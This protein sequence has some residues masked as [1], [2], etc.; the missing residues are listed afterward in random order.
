MIY[1]PESSTSNNDLHTQPIRLVQISDSHLFKETDKTL[2]GLNTEQSFLAVLKLILQEQSRVDLLITTGDIAQQP[3][4]E[5][6][7]RYLALTSKIHAP[8]FCVQGNHDLKQPFYES[9]TKNEL[10]CEVVMG[11]WC[12]ILLDST[13]D[14]EISGSFSQKTLNYIDEALT[15]QDDKHVLIALH[16]NPIAVGCIWL[17]QHML[18]DS[19]AFLATINRHSNVKL[20]MHGHVH[21]A[22]EHIEQGIHYISCPSTSL[23]FK[24]RCK[25]FEIDQ[26]NPGYRW[27]DLLPDGHFNTGV[28]RIAGGIN[29]SIEYASLGY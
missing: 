5:T 29:N 15:R 18:K 11:N 22:F 17:D 21:Q 25:N 13:E 26:L 27:F 14:H 12:C 3:D 20:V 9:I 1:Y 7:Q 23:Q 19:T 6:Y 24:P 10:P 4:I 28:S 8:H 16:H 2:L